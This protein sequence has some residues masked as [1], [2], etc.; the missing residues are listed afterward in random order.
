MKACGLLSTPSCGCR[1]TKADVV[2][3]AKDDRVVRETDMRDVPRHCSRHGQHAVR[4]S[5]Q[6][7]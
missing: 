6:S 2:A 1:H 3:L 5:K 4:D 7:A